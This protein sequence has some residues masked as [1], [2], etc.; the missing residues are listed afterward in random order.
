MAVTDVPPAATPTGDG[1]DALFELWDR[2]ARPFDVVRTVAA[3]VGLSPPVVSQLVGQALATSPE[4][5]RLV[6]TMPQTVRGLATSMQTQV[7][8]CKGELRGPVLWSETLSARASSFGDPDLYVCQ[9]PS[10]AYD[11]DENRVLRAALVTVRNAAR[12]ATESAV[13]RG[14]A[15]PLLREARRLGNEAAKYVEHPS[16]QSV[17]RERPNA[18]AIKK[19]R[20]GKN[21]KTYQ[22]AL[23]MLDRAANP[24][25]PEQVLALCDRRTR[26]QHRVLMGLVHRLEGTGNR[27][28]DFRVERGALYS[29][30][31]QYYH[32]RVLG[33]ATHLSGIVLGSLLIDVPDHITDPD[34]SRAEERMRARATGRETMVV[35]EE[36]DIDAA[37]RRAIELV[38]SPA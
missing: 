7:E 1:D 14:A 32:G 27:L 28:P 38:Q 24:L 11:I 18:R 22:P 9:T 2:L 31:V 16:L 6:A 23:D 20:S 29:G 13:D 10:R 35:M 8:R 33:D 26:A 36:A 19:T 34:R 25:R 5:R 3:L 21:R 37:L 30:P 15:D 17:S 12:L 4:A